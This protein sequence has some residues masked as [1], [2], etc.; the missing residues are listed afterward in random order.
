MEINPKHLVLTRL[1]CNSL[2]KTTLVAENSGKTRAEISIN[3]ENYPQFKVSL[4]KGQ[5][6]SELSAC[7]FSLN[8]GAAQRIYLYF[9]PKDLASYNFYLPTVVNGF[10]V[11]QKLLA[12]KVDQSIKQINLVNPEMQENLSMPSLR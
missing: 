1:H 12:S 2:T 8:P 11:T 5:Y 3:L 10:N 6:N 9:T 4:S 7:K